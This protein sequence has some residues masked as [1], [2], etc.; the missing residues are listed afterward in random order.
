[1]KALS[2]FAILFLTLSVFAAP[3]WTQDREEAEELYK[4]AQTADRNIRTADQV[5]PKLLQALGILE[6][7]GDKKRM[8]DVNL[9]LGKRYEIQYNLDP[10]KVLPVY[11]KSLALYKEMNDPKGEAE[12]LKALASFTYRSNHQH[13]A[14]DYSN[15]QEYTEKALAA[16]RKVKDR[17]GEAWSLSWLASLHRRAGQYDK[18]VE[19]YEASLAIDRE[20]GDKEKQVAPLTYLGGAY[21]DWG[22]YEKAVESYERLLA[23]CRELK[24]A[25]L[26]CEA[27]ALQ[28]IG[29]TY[30]KWGNKEKEQ[31]YSQ[32]FRKV[33]AE[34]MT[35]KQKAK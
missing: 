30:G 34:M 1:M 15:V 20:L 24:A 27:D 18:A 12:T 2:L 22:K 19:N 31:E 25:N 6:R 3:V 10:A 16:C 9:S 4:E 29:M 21:R 11:E 35:R 32:R 14:E 33:L 26:E 23:L 5:E 8:A 17:E 7:L 13:K 28:G